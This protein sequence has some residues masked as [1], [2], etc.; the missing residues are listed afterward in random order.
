MPADKNP[1]S[2][3]AVETEETNAADASSAAAVDAS[4]DA[5]N[6]YYLK[7]SDTRLTRQQR[8]RKI[9]STVVP[10]L[11]AVLIMGGFAW[12]LLRDF[13]NLYPGRGGGSP[14]PT[15]KTYTHAIGKKSLEDT[16]GAKPY[17][18]SSRSDSSAAS[19]SSSKSEKH[20]TGSD[21]A[22][23][24]HSACA[25]LGLLGLCCPTDKGV[26]LECCGA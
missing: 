19:D 2:Y 20:G 24:A 16:T 8:T 18:I 17:V 10:I 26:H 5:E 11:I 22:C 21:S 6:T 7:D 15:V 14:E 13:N 25:K 1:V 12:Y 23:A 3:G 9:L 4:F